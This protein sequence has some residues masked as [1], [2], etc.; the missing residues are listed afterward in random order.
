MEKTFQN[1]ARWRP[2]H[3][4]H[5]SG[6]IARSNL[7]SIIVSSVYQGVEIADSYRAHSFGTVSD[8]RYSNFVSSTEREQSCI[9]LLPTMTTTNSSGLLWLL[10]DVIN[11]YCSI[12]YY[13]LVQQLGGVLHGN[14]SQGCIRL[15]VLAKILTSCQQKDSVHPESWPITFPYRLFSVQYIF[16]LKHSW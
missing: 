2:L 13:S 3:T 16:P 6:G 14:S 7:N 5:P 9:V 8:L 1:T 15:A 11:E 4:R 10:H 12:E